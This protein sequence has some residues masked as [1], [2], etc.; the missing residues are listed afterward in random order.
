MALD[1]IYTHYL[2]KELNESIENTR[3]ES[4]WL[5]GLMFVFSL[6]IQKQRHHLIIN[7]NASFTST[8][9]TKLA[10]PKKD[11]ST[12]LGQLKKYLEG[13]ILNNITQYKS[14]RVIEFNFTV[15]D[16]I[17]G[18]VKRKLIFEAMGR[19]AN[20]YLIEDG[21]IID[22]YKKMFVLEGRHLIPNAT[23]SYFLSDKQDASQYV[24]DP[25]LSPKDITNK[26]LG[27]SLRLAKYLH[28][29]GKHP[30][31]LDVSPTLS[32]KENKSYFFNI[33]ET[34]TLSF[35]FLSEALDSRVMDFKDHKT[36]YKSF[37]QNQLKKL[38]KKQIQLTK[39]LESAKD[40]LLD[41]E[42]GD[43][44]YSSGLNLKQ[45]LSYIGDIPLDDTVNL[46][47]NAQKFYNRYQKGKRAIDF[48][49]P[50]IQKVRS[51]KEVFENYLIELQLT[52][53]DSLNDFKEILE[54]Y[55]FMKQKNK[56]HR[57][58]KHKVKLLT[59]S[60]DDTLYFIGKN[61]HQN[62]H[63]VN[64]LGQSNDYWFHVK[65]APGSH[66]LVRTFELTEKV[67]RTAAMLAAHFSSIN[68]SSS[69]PVNYTLFRYVSKIGGRPASFVKIKNEKTIYIDIDNEIIDNILQNA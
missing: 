30:F 39:Q 13:G 3:V 8:Y 1:G 12:F 65:D 17:Y 59:I 69:I 28:Q 43:Y 6:Y 52:D 33:F 41:K 36:V 46:T 57:P 50:E 10:P 23:F 26:Y 55:G 40:M 5:N 44:I 68:T 62:A 58:T 60:L 15:Y 2:I 20:L 63:L 4:I 29:T 22:L 42:K 66:V 48:L 38:D 11:N 25:L 56:K 24:F 54:P 21:K 7:L 51:E 18:P 49:E 64:Q 19:H 53:N 67:L 37:I 32:P 9:L 35:N 47:K 14:D 45:T 16:Y 34:P 27:I 31:K 61:A